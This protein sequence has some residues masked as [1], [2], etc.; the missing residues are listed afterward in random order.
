MTDN[1]LV[2]LDS[3]LNDQNIKVQV[4]NLPYGGNF[5]DSDSLNGQKYDF[6]PLN[7]NICYFWSFWGLNRRNVHHKT[8][9]PL[10]RIIWGT[11]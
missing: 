3:D 11:I 9:L 8:R 2:P 10:D 4:V 5:D 6:E 7:T 1:V